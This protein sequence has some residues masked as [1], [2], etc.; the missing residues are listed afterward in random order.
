MKKEEYLAISKI[1]K[2]TTLEGIRRIDAFIPYTGFLK[3]NFDL[4]I[5]KFQHACKSPVACVK[6]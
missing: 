2:Q 1:L 3:T 6:L 5:L 4:S